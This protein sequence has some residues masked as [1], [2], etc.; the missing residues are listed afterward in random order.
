MRVLWYPLLT[1]TIINKEFNVKNI[2]KCVSLTLSP[3]QWKNVGKNL[4]INHQRE[5]GTLKNS[6][7]ACAKE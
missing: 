4:Q 3:P 5:R 2:E 1:I 6:I 7:A